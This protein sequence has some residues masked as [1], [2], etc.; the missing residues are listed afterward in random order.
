MWLIRNAF[1]PKKSWLSNKEPEKTQNRTKI[2]CP[3]WVTTITLA[4]EFDFKTN[5][6]G[7]QANNKNKISCNLVINSFPGQENP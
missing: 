3:C 5:L 6:F 4:V 2:Y 1:V 7:Q